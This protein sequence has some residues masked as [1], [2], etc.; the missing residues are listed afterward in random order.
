MSCVSVLWTVLSV[1]FTGACS[2]AIISPFWFERVP[3]PDDVSSDNS[4]FVAFGLLRFCIKRN[5]ESI[6]EM[7]EWSDFKNCKFY[8]SFHGI[9]SLFWKF[10]VV[11]YGIGVLLLL[12][13][14]LL[15][16]IS[17]CFKKVCKRSVFGVAGVVQIS[18][19]IFLVISL[20]MFPLGFKSQF[21]SQHCGLTDMFNPG[22]CSISWAY[23][24]AIMSTG[25]LM[26]CPV[27]ARHLMVT[28]PMAKATVV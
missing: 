18:A 13:A 17:C 11:L 10:S 19:V 2:L 23:T 21:V 15:A 4:S 1:L 24:L 9:P 6:L 28:T 27:M 25:L 16:H 3:D 26:L 20:V 8:S 22:Q 14:I 5:L 12:V 7:D